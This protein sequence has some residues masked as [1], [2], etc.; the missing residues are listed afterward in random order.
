MPDRLPP[1]ILE[2]R[3][4]AT[5]AY[6]VDWTLCPE[7]FRKELRFREFRNEMIK[8]KLLNGRSVCYRTSGWSLCPR[9]YPNDQTTYDPVTSADQVEEEDNVFCQV[10][11]GNRFYGHLVKHKTWSHFGQVWVFRISDLKG[12]TENGW[13]HLEHI[14]G[15]LAPPPLQNV[16]AFLGYKDPP[17]PLRRLFRII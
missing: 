1:F 17:L 2:G 14:Y 4:E 15:R 16:T 6:D 13:C 12:N 8:E 7:D 9:V 11:P 5:D 3:H 10:Q